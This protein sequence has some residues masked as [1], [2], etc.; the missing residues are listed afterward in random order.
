MKETITEIIEE[1]ENIAES[2]RRKMDCVQLPTES[3]RTL[4]EK[5]RAE[6][7]RL[8]QIVSNLKAAVEKHGKEI[9]GARIKEEIAL[10]SALNAEEA[11]GEL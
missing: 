2:G 6:F 8:D 1:M 5:I 10:E 4:A 3:D 7:D 11:W 9:N